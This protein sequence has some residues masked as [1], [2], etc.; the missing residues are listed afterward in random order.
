M[1][2]TENERESAGELGRESM[3]CR[4]CDSGSFVLPS[5]TDA[6]VER[7]HVAATALGVKTWQT[8]DQGAPVIKQVT[9]SRF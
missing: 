8:P 2:K 4:D 1:A 3:C 9:D 6:E 5:Y 7:S